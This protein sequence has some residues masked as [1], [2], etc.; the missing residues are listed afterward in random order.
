MSGFFAA[1]IIFAIF[2]VVAAL[3]MWRVRKHVASRADAEARMA[4]AMQE[5]QMLAVR[6][7]TQRARIETAAESSSG[8]RRDA[9]PST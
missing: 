1:G 6:L 2:A 3:V 8:N 4:A 5:L 7:E 9:T